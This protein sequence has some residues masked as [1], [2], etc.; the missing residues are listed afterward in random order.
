MWVWAGSRRRWRIGKPG[1]LQPMGS[2]R[3]GHGW[4][5]AQP[6][7]ASPHRCPAPAVLLRPEGRA[8][9][10]ALSWA[11]GSS[12]C[13]ALPRPGTSQPSPLLAPCTEAFR[14]PEVS[15]LWSVARVSCSHWLK[16]PLPPSLDRGRAE[17]LWSSGLCLVASGPVRWCWACIPGPVPLHESLPASNKEWPLPVLLWTRASALKGVSLLVGLPVFNQRIGDLAFN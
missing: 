6:T 4:S 9:S 3:V 14:A 1:M 15:A 16:P 8:G 10:P 2:Q 17:W 7:L 11:P 5:T 13:A 12:L